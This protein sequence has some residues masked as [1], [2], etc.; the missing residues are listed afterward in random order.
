M[1]HLLLVLAL[2]S[3]GQGSAVGSDR[4]A[5]LAPVHQFLDSLNKGD[6]KSAVAACAEETEI[7]DEVPPYEWHGAG[8]CA[9]WADSFAAYAEKNGIT[10]PIVRIGI[11][12]HVDV[13]GDHA[14]TVL[15]ATYTYKQN[16]KP[17]TEAG[18]TFTVALQKEA[19]GWKITAWTWTKH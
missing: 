10:D 4:T 16:G 8:G 9:K 15:P 5:V 2:T 17:M 18:A 14:Y 6:V 13:I 3:F 1:H 19:S 11:P 12:R 7:I